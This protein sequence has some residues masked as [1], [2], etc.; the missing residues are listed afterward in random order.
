MDA[1][2]NAI[3]N[4][5]IENQVNDLIENDDYYL[6]LAT[7]LKSASILKEE[8]RHKLT[9]FFQFKEQIARLEQ[10]QMLI[11]DLMPLSVSP[12]EFTKIMEEI[13]NSGQHFNTFMKNTGVSDKPILLQEMLGLSDETLLHIYALGKDLVEKDNFQDAGSIFTLLT[14]LAP[15]VQSYWILEGVCFEKLN[16]HEESQAAFSAAKL[17]S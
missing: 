16:L 4:K 12:L 9:D 3:L 13:N 11:T 8:H 1:N 7:P 5:L 17:L 2:S 6:G 15:H 14:T 10:A